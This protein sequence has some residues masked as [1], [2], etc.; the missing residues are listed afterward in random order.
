MPSLPH[1]GPVRPQTIEHRYCT[2]SRS[3]ASEVQT[4]DDFTGHRSDCAVCGQNLPVIYL[5]DRVKAFVFPWHD[6]VD[7]SRDRPERAGS[8]QSTKRCDR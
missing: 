7:D 4:S 8:D 1:T 3:R 6:A 2:G 5:P